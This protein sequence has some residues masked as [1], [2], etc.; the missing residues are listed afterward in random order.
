MVNSLIQFFRAYDPFEVLVEFGI[1]WICVYVV[2]RFLIGTRGAGVVRGLLVVFVVFTLGIRVLGES[3]GVFER[4]RFLYDTLLS[5]LAILLIV[6]FAPE[7]RQAMIRV[8]ELIGRRAAR[9]SDLVSEIATA[10]EY[11]SKNQFGAIIV[12][13]RGVKLGG[14]VESGIKLD[15]RVSAPLIESIFYPNNPLHDLAVVVRGD[16]IA[17]ANVQL[18]L[19]EHT[20]VPRQLGSRHRA[21]LGISTDSDS[22]VVVVSEETGF[23]RIA[24]RGQLSIPIERDAFAARLAECFRSED[25]ETDEDE[26]RAEAPTVAGSDE[27]PAA[28]GKVGVVERTAGGA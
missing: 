18:P 8:S 7:L 3:F 27:P 22:I 15:A 2:F 13:E 19:V 11:L 20:N 1:I 5:F 12:I 28:T 24:E 16:R 4:L 10:V 23:I 21:A 17:A 14:L 26:A 25:E 9:V 6:V